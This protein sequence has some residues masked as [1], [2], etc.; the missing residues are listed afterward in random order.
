MNET[1]NK[2]KIF[3][4]IIAFVILSAG[5]F[6]FISKDVFFGKKKEIKEEKT[7]PEFSVAQTKSVLDS[8]TDF[9]DKVV[10]SKSVSKI[11]DIDQSLRVFV[12]SESENVEINKEIYTDGTS[13][14]GISYVVNKDIIN[15]QKIL[16]EVSTNRFF[17]VV[18]STRASVAFL[19]NTKSDKYNVKISGE[20]I[21]ENKTKVYIRVLNIK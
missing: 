16:R 6:S 19:I 8:K 4:L 2:P 21:E 13:G 3:W 17:N 12:V 11:S 20:K 1:N 10:K 14:W 15:T 9:P 18:I 7:D 5:V